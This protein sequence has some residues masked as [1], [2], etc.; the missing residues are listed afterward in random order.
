MGPKLKKENEATRGGGG[1]AVIK[2]MEGCSPSF[3]L[4]QMLDSYIMF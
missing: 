3:S 1:G 4:P 2:A